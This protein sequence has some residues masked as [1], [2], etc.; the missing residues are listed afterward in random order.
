M[1]H[2]RAR[3]AREVRLRILVHHRIASRDGQSVH[4]EEL[5]RALLAQGEE[6]VLVGPAGFRQ[7]EFGG[8][9]RAID[10]LKALAPAALYELMEIGYNAVAFVRLLRAARQVRPDV[11]Y[12]RFSLYLLIGPLVARLLGLPLLLEVNSPL[13]E[14]R[15]ADHEIRLHRLAR[16][17]QRFLWRHADHVLP[18][19]GVLADI[20]AAYGVP[21]ARIT[22][23][24]N[25]VEAARFA[26]LPETAAA[27][28]ALGI[29]A[30]R[31][32]IGFTG[33]VR[34]WNATHTLLR[35]IETH[36][37]AHDLHVLI[38]G[39]GPARAELEAYAAQH[40]I[41]GRVTVTGLVAREAV[42]AHLAAFDVAVLPGVTPYASPLKLFEYMQAGRAVVAPDQ[43]NLREI[44]TDGRDGLLF[45][46]G[47]DE[48]MAAALLR[49]C[50]EPALRARLGAAARETI[51]ARG[52]SWRHNAL[53]V[54]AIARRLAGGDAR[55]AR[56]AAAQPGRGG[57]P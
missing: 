46:P 1:A 40:G 53:V 39:D 29:P 23:V 35:L 50:A 21:R 16:A 8:S 47:S 54:S 56:L 19:T 26:D 5:T 28:R 12:E 42:P 41:A 7:T 36:G 33:F 30:A 57:S 27:K 34:G 43:P 44:V 15:A 31:V 14:E 2:A 9:N 11:I 13:F 55:A 32:V 25:G 38:V 48:A 18:V 3:P 17:C 45:D 22:V 49:L 4:L 37:E 24:P 20:V 51:A 6:V 52:L 10:R